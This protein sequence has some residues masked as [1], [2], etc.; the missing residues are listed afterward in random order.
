[1]DRTQREYYAYLDANGHLVNEGI[2]ASQAFLQELSNELSQEAQ[3]LYRARTAWGNYIAFAPA[4]GGVELVGIR[5]LGMASLK[6]LDRVDIG[7]IVP[8]GPGEAEEVVPVETPELL[9]MLLRQ[10]F[11]QEQPESTDSM[12]SATD[13]TTT[14]RAINSEIVICVK[15]SSSDLED[16]VLIGE[17]DPRSDDVRRPLRLPRGDFQRLFSLR[18]ELTQE[19]LAGKKDLVREMYERLSLKAANPTLALAPYRDG[20]EYDA[21]LLGDVVEKL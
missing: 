13:T 11:H 2:V 8:L 17:W 15:A 12:L 5:L 3:P 21:Y 6:G 1:I 10:D 9:M 19:M 16:E 20:G 18:G 14:E 7:E 4:I